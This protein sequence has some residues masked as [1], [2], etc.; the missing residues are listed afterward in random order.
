[1]DPVLK[2][3]KRENGDDIWATHIL[4]EP[5]DIENVTAAI[6]PDG[7]ANGRWGKCVYSGDNDVCDQQ[8][9][10]LNVNERKGGGR[11][12]MEIFPFVQVVNIQYKDGTTASFTMVAFTQQVCSRVTRIHGSHGELIGDMSTYTVTDFRTGETTRHIPPN[13]GGG[14]GGGDMGLMRSFIKAC[15]ERDQSALEVRPEDILRSHL[16]VFAAE[17][18]RLKDQNVSY[19]EFEKR[20]MAGLDG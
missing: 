1:L 5:P 6:Q 3:P 11:V 13:E 14:H 19:D 2:G 18:S 20:C 12:L 9:S 17:E 16:M 10:V 7:I 8:V 15:A 4:D